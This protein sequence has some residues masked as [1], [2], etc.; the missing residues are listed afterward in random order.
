MA[1]IP[2]KFKPRA[3]SSA[4]RKTITLYLPADER[5]FVDK[6]SMSGGLP[7]NSYIRTLIRD[8]MKR[9]ARRAQ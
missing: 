2:P 7:R 1:A 6:Q 4:P 9:A 3:Y 5:D 8:A